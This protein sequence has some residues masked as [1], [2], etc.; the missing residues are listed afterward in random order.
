MLRG[1][2]VGEEKWRQDGT[3]TPEGQ[4]GRGGVPMGGEA[5]SPR[6]DQGGWGETLRGLED[7]R[8]MRLVFP[9]PTWAPG[10]LLESQAWSSIL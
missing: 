4:L 9:L 5:H 8:G 1:V 7:W 10:S 2:G 6:V 3:C